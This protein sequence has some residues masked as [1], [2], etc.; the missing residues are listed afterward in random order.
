MT[1]ETDLRNMTKKSVRGYYPSTTSS[2]ITF[3]HA[4]GEYE[5]TITQRVM[6]F[7]T[8]TMRSMRYID[9]LEEDEQ[10]PN[11]DAAWDGFMEDLDIQ[12]DQL[13]EDVTEAT[14]SGNIRLL[15]IN[16]IQ[17]RSFSFYYQQENKVEYYSVPKE[18]H[19]IKKHII[20][21]IYDTLD[22]DTKFEKHNHELLDHLCTYWGDVALG[23]LTPKNALIWMFETD[24][25]NELED[26]LLLRVIDKG[27]HEVGKHDGWNKF[28]YVLKKLTADDVKDLYGWP[29]HRV[30]SLQSTMEEYIKE[31]RDD[32]EE[33]F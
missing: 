13:M 26:D 18:V 3:K 1:E 15:I 21:R 22:E 20:E 27:F 23:Y 28:V 16:I 33:G 31:H 6:D 7:I 9:R 12:C 10:E 2:I 14:N 8:G 5:K 24:Y 25:N 30:V 4:M 19:D 11:I 29:A 17:G 32:V